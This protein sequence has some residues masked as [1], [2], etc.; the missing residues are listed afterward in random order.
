MNRGK[1]VEV[2]EIKRTIPLALVRLACGSRVF[3]GTSELTKKQIDDHWKMRRT[4][5]V[6]GQA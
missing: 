2:I 4:E 5:T 1:I 3:R 6:D